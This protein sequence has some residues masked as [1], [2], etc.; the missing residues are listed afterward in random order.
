MYKSVCIM[1]TSLGECMHAWI[2]GVWSMETIKHDPQ[3]Y[4]MEHPN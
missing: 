2:N 3:L 1:H 4:A